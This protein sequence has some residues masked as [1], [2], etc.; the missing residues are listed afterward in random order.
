MDSKSSPSF[1]KD[2]L[3]SLIAELPNKKGSR[4]VDLA[5]Y[6]AKSAHPD[7][8][9]TK[10]AA[11]TAIWKMQHGERRL[12]HADILA[13]SEFFKVSDGIPTAPEL[14]E[15]SSGCVRVPFYDVVASAG[16]PAIVPADQVRQTVLIPFALLPST[17]TSTNIAM[18]SIVGDSME[19]EL[20]HGDRVLI[21]IDDKMPYPPGLFVLDDGMGLV[22]K[23]VEM[24]RGGQFLRLIS[25][26]TV[27]QPY[28]VSVE[29]V[30]VTG[31]VVAKITR[32]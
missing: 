6:W 3:N 18:I 30:T 2:W 29:D 1:D 22:V 4:K 28:E 31:R 10:S 16:N 17:V 26:N 8:Q 5:L 7:K 24:I 19:P 15:D 23:R 21:N 14:T 13:I 20:R 9:M 11:M 32:A 27:Y 12:Q 25:T